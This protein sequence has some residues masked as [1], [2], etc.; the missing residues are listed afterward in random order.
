MAEDE[1]VTILQKDDK[2]FAVQ[3]EGGLALYGSGKQ[4]ALQH[5]FS[6]QVVHTT[7]QPLVHVICWQEDEACPVEVSGRVALVGDKEAPIEVRMTHVFGNEMN[8]NVQLKPF[9]HT[10]KLDTALADPIHHALQLR[11]PVQLRFCNPWH[12][13]SDYQV[14]VKVGKSTVI[15]IRLT[16]ATVATPQPCADEQPCPPVKDYPVTP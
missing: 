13:A 9:D 8:E 6:G 2:P 14:D 16:G 1:N 3:A 12:V 5:V 10:M 15:S 4:P 7:P 11:T